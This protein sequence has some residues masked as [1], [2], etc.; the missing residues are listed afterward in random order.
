MTTMAWLREGLNV[1]KWIARTDGGTLEHW[2][3]GKRLEETWALR[4]WEKP[5]PVASSIRFRSTELFPAILALNRFNA[6]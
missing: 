3:N 5:V 6:G 1:F 2:V 4:A